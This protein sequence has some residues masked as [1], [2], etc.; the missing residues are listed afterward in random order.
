MS[1]AQAKAGAPLLLCLTLGGSACGLFLLFYGRFVS[2][3]TIPSTIGVILQIF[4]I[5]MAM[6]FGLYLKNSVD[7][8]QGADFIRTFW[9]VEIWFIALLPLRAIYFAFMQLLNLTLR[10]CF[11]ACGPACRSPFGSWAGCFFSP[12]CRSSCISQYACLS[13][14]FCAAVGENKNFT[15]ISH[16]TLTIHKPFD[17]III[18][19]V[20]RRDN[21]RL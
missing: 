8:E 12:A 19:L 6:G 17:I 2:A 5:A 11:R 18:A 14:W 21:M 16:F 20:L 9:R 13:L 1:P 10:L 3:S 7:A 15:A 4:A